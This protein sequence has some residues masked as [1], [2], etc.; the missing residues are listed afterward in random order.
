[1]KRPRRTLPLASSIDASSIDAA[2]NPTP[3]SADAAAIAM[4]KAS[5]PVAGGERGTSDTTGYTH[6]NAL[7]PEGWQPFG[8]FQQHTLPSAQF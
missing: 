7:I 2:H 1:M 6:Q 8:A 4:P 3:H 5:K